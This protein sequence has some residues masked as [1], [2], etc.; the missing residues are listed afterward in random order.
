MNLEKNKEFTDR[1]QIYFEGYGK[2]KDFKCKLY[3]DESVQTTA[4]RL[5]RFLYHMT[6]ATKKEIKRLEHLDINENV[7]CAQDWISK[8]VVVPKSNGKVCLRL[9]TRTINTVIKRE[10]YPIPTLNS[11]IDEI[12]GYKAFAKFDMR[13]AYT[14][15][16]LEEESREITNYNTDDGIYH[17]KL[18]AF[19]INNAFEIFH[20][21]KSKI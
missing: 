10:T 19:G 20:V 11:I 18:L 21:Y 5:G 12:H 2:L 13:E 17:H 8:L 14:P 7:E 4:Q 1:I 9:D 15:I 16:E 3:V 6:R